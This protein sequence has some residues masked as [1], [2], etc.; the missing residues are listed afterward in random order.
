MNE[1][2]Y[3]DHV[4]TIRN[5][6]ETVSKESM[7]NAAEEAKEFYEPGEDGVFD[8]GVSGDGTWR[9]RGYSSAYGVITAISTVTG[10]VLDVEIMS[11]ECKE[12]MVWRSKEGTVEF[13]EGRTPA[14][15]PGKLF[16]LFGVGGC[17]WNACH[18]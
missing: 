13:Q 2:S 18:I 7:Q 9:R 1:N 4:A 15:L 12:C 11:K 8:I 14:S 5:S 10:K 3:R 17:F 16:W 6:A